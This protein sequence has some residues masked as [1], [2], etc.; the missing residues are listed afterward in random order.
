MP[1][2]KRIAVFG[3][4]TAAAFL[5]LK[6]HRGPGFVAAGVAVAVLASEYPEQMERLWDNAPDYLERGTQILATIA[7]IKERLK[8]EGPREVRGWKQ[9]A[10][11]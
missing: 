6:G 2:W 7:S 5:I 4:F 11:Y 9:A 8:E 1:N 10:D 3:S